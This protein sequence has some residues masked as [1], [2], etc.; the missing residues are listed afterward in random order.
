MIGSVWKARWG[1][2][3]LLALWSA[4][5]AA[6]SIHPLGAAAALALLVASTW[7]MAA[8]GTYASQVSRDVT[9]ASARATIPL[10]LL[11]SSCLCCWWPGR[12]TSVVMGAGSLPFVNSLCLVTCGDVAQAMRQGTFSYLTT[13]GI[14]TNEGAG[15]VFVTYLIA[16]TGYAAVAAWFTRAAFDCFDRVAGRPERATESR[17]GALARRRKVVNHCAAQGMEP[18]RIG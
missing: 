3:L 13:I 1:I 10:I 8:L 16:T 9:Q 4:G 18:I 14:F 11:I 17:A 12:F 7:F 6:G 15:R 5:L 2:V